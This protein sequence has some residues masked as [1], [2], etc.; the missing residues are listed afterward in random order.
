MKELGYFLTN[1]D[2]I[3]YGQFKWDYIKDFYEVMEYGQKWR[4][5]DI[6]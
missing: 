6:S 4:N 3:G 2:A 5:S 1:R